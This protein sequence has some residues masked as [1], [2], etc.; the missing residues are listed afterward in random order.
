MATCVDGLLVEVRRS[1]LRTVV[2]VKKG[3]GSGSLGKNHEKDTNSVI[4]TYTQ[5]ECHR[6]GHFVDYNSPPA[7]SRPAPL[8][9]I[10]EEEQRQ[11]VPNT[12]FWF[13]R[14][15]TNRTTPPQTGALPNSAEQHKNHVLCSRQVTIHNPG[16]PTTSL[17]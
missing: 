10:P 4:S 17:H 6:R 5:L 13:F 2:V 15:N 3:D 8:Q 14:T 7:L 11:R 9:K 12:W 1:G 16:K